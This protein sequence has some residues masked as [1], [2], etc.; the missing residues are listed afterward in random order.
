MKVLR[1]ISI[2]ILLICF[3]GCN[4]RYDNHQDKEETTIDS[5]IVYNNVVPAAYDTILEGDTVITVDTII[6]N[7]TPSSKYLTELQD[8]ISDRLSHLKNNPL[9]QNVWAIAVLK[10]AVQVSMAINTPF[11][12]NE[13]KQY[14]LNSSYI[15]FDG[16]S[17]PQPISAL[18]NS[19]VELT[20]IKLQPDSS[21]FSVNSPFA[22]FTLTND[23]DKNIDFDV[24]YII[25]F[26]STDGI[27]Y[28]LPHPGI[29]DDMGITL[30][31]TG[32]YAIKVALN[33]RLN[34]NS[35]G[36]YRLYKQ[37]RL[38]GE[39][40]EVWLMTEFMLD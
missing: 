8:L 40:K 13:F 19:I 38:E 14:V 11:W 31:P 30:M 1:N 36:I 24:K 34:N 12:H 5:T 20:T 28:K 37:I 21:H 35:P 23:S 3:V 4:H 27:W 18:V 6:T 22:T 25:G 2:T 9:Q 7:H 32:K 26:K 29:W 16:P 39:K 33:P 17:T 10:D 15:I